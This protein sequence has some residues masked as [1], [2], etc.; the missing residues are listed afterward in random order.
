MDY[1]TFMSRVKKI[2]KNNQKIE[3]NKNLILNIDKTGDTFEFSLLPQMNNQSERMW[4]FFFKFFIG[5]FFAY[6]IIMSTVSSSFCYLKKGYFDPK[7][8]YHPNKFM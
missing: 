4:K 6:I 1:I 7:F 3:N 8:V 2:Q 5:G